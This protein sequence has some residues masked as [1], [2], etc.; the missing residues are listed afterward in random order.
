MTRPLTHRMRHTLG[1]LDVD[2]HWVA[3]RQIIANDWVRSGYRQLRGLEERGLIEME[4]L[5][6][7]TFYACG[8]ATAHWQQAHYFAR[9]TAAGQAVLEGPWA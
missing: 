7:Y 3:T 5:A 9:L 4:H 2:G 8:T 6:P 1:L